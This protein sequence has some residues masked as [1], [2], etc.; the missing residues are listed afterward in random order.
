MHARKS[1]VLGKYDEAD[2]D[3]CMYESSNKTSRRDCL[4]SKRECHGACWM[5]AYIYVLYV[6]MNHQTKLHGEV[7]QNLQ[8]NALELTCMYACIYRCV[9][10]YV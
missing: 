6:C 7:D 3:V 5:Y 10:M 4:K 1:C 2:I 9:C 8:E